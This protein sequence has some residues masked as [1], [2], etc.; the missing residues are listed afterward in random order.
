MKQFT[1]AAVALFATGLIPVLAAQP[2]SADLYDHAN[3][4]R[5]SNRAFDDRT[6][7]VTVVN[8]QGTGIDNCQNIGVR[9]TRTWGYEYYDKHAPINI[10]VKGG[11]RTFTYTFKADQRARDLCFRYSAS[12]SFHEAKDCKI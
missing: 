2:A 7:C 5:V 10:T 1:K 12:G 4:I 3:G 11:G 6:A 9:N 8:P